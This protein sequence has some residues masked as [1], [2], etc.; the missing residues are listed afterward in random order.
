MKRNGYLALGSTG[1]VCVAS[2]SRSGDMLWDQLLV[3][4]LEQRL[5][6]LPLPTFATSFYWQR[7]RILCL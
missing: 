3:L 4:I 6:S 7:T 5:E 2:L 1:H